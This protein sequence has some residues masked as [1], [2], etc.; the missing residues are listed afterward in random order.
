[1]RYLFCTYKL[2]TYTT[3]TYGCSVLGISFN[4]NNQDRKKKNNKKNQ[5]LTFFIAIKCPRQLWRC[6][7][8]YV[9]VA[10]F[11]ADHESSTNLSFISSLPEDTEFSCRVLSSSEK[12]FRVTWDDASG[13]PWSLYLPP[14]EAILALLILLEMTPNLILQL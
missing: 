7:F 6:S 2:L 1:M 8:H 5:P 4:Y 14:P 3:L 9:L 13:R 12:G 10:C 11:W